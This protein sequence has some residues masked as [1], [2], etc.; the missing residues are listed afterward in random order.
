MTTCL[1]KDAVE[2]KPF[3]LEIIMKKYN[4]AGLL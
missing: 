4:N 3:D 2:I 1:L